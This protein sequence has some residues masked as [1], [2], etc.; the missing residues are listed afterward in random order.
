MLKTDFDMGI[1]DMEMD[2]KLSVRDVLVL[3][4]ALRLS[5]ECDRQYTYDK[6]GLYSV[7]V[8]KDNKELGDS[9][10]KILSSAFSV[11]EGSI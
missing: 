1:L 4:A 5:K 7:N 2:A 11:R 3:Y 6:F 9:L 8:D 10:R